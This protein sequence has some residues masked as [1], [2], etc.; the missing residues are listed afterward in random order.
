MGAFAFPFASPFGSGFSFVPGPGGFSLSSLDATAGGGLA[1][2]YDQ[3]INPTTLDYVRNDVGEWAET[4]DT[5][6]TML[7]MLELEL[8]ASPFDPQDGT[9]IKAKLRDG[10][11]VTPEELRAETLRAAGILQSAGLITDLAVTVRDSANQVL[12]DQSGRTLVRVDWRDLASGSPVDL[13]LQP[14]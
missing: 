10:D 2:Q 14:G 3:L 5:R 1:G 11:P 7:L 13:V 8:G 9:T 12:R 6:T 4:A